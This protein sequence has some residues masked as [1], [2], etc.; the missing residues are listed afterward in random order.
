M[1]ENKEDDI[2]SYQDMYERITTALGILDEVDEEIANAR[3]E[4]VQKTQLGPDRL[5]DASHE[6]YALGSAIPNLMFHV[7]MA[8]A[9]L[10]KE[11]VP[12]GK[13]DFLMYFMR[14]Y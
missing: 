11:G 9:I 12:L 4:E 14:V 3:S 6:A 2:V 1:P 13:R 8:Y 10:R 7:S 5:M